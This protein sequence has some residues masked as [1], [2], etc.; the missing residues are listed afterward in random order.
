MS[1]DMQNKEGSAAQMWHI[2]T[3]NDDIQGIS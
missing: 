2:I 1:V 3:T